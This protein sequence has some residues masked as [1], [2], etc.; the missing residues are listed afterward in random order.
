M[1]LARLNPPFLMRY[2]RA[3]R[4]VLAHLPFAFNID[5]KAKMNVL[6]VL[7][8]L[9]HPAARAQRVEVAGASLAVDVA[10]SAE[11]L[12]YYTPRNVIRHA[13]R[14]ALYALIRRAF[15]HR[16]GIFVDVGANLGLYSLLARRHGA[17][18]LLFEPEP[19]HLDFLRRNAMYLGRVV[20]VAL[21]D[22][23]GT[24][25]FH[26]GDAHHSGASSLCTTA[27]EG[28][29]AIYESTVQVDVRTF[30]AF[31]AEQD[32]DLQAIRLIKV[33]VEGNEAQTL[34]GMQGYASRDDA[35]PLW[36]EVRG[37]ESDR[38]ADSY[39]DATAMLEPHGYRPFVMDGPT[40][41]PFQ[42]DRDVRR[43]FD[44]LFLVPERHAYLLAA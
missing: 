17:E 44:L 16:D 25:A 27:G 18:T 22:C 12:L 38:G 43:V 41:R 39:R 40:P 5:G 7:D 35:A 4:D 1:P 26:V 21:S 2:P 3:L 31:T 29:G 19:A 30:D 20:P 37:P 33:D 34:R 10:Q 36:C 6:C 9:F 14:S 15:E 24:A 42:P 32:V 28:G 13:Q 23:C 8:P 11:R